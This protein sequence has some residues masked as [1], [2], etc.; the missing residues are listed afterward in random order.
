MSEKCIKNNMRFLLTGLS[1]LKQQLIKKETAA[2][3]A[4]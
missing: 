2:Q 3:A 4:G 1:I